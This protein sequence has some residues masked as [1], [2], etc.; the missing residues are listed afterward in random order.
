MEYE[1]HLMPFIVISMAEL[2]RGN[3]VREALRE[4]DPA[5]LDAFLGTSDEDLIPML[6]DWIVDRRATE[7]Q[8]EAGQF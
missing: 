6:R 4:R 7:Q 2:A 8:L 3:R 5:K 1:Q